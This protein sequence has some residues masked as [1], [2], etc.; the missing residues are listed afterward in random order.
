MKYTR[1]GNTG[2]E[3]SSLCYGTMSFGGDADRE[4]SA[5]IYKKCRDSGINFFDCADVYP[6]AHAPGVSEEILGDL[7]QDDR[8]ELVITTKVYNPVGP[9]RNKRGLSRRHIVKAVEDSLKRLKTDRID[10][11][12]LHKFDQ[13][14]PMEDSLRAIEDLLRS[15]KILYTGV[16]NWAAWQVATGLGAQELHHWQPLTCLQPMYN[17]AKRQAEVELLPLA[18]DRDL[19]VITYSPL[20]GGLLSGKYSRTHRPEKG[21]IVESDMYVKRYG[22]EFYFDL[23]EKFAAHAKSRGY[24]PVTLAVAWVAAND[25]VTAPIIGARSVEQLEPS[26]EAGDLDMDPAWYAEVSALAPTPPPATDR[27]EERHGIVR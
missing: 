20:G 26:L 14:V 21:R 5:A 8:D 19:A 27:S 1:L 24:H 22:E 9:D 12:F 4:T 15:G 10:I 6:G 7:M 18:R 2:V 3:V 16:S 23:A 11:Y 17:L 13:S 25:A